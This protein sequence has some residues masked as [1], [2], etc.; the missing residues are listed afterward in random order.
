[1]LETEAA[2]VLGIIRKYEEEQ[3]RFPGTLGGGEVIVTLLPEDRTE[4]KGLAPAANP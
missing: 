1:M 4:K 3:A 2:Y